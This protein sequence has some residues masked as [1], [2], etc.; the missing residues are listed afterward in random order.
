MGRFLD[1]MDRMFES[2]GMPSMQTRGGGSFGELWNPQIEVFQRDKNM[3]V[4]ADL[5]GITQDNVSVQVED[6]VLTISG[7]RTDDRKEQR[8]GY[9]HS[10]RS[11][12]SF[13]R[14]IA[15]PQGVSPDTVQ[16][17]FE[18]GVLEVSVPMPEAKRSGRKIEIGKPQGQTQPSAQAKTPSKNGN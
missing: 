11:Y 2:M 3:I 10:E 16:A 1:E 8:E 6:D 4:R 15:L 5:P 17:T 13:Q 9:Y 7:V 12:G 14:S 18:N